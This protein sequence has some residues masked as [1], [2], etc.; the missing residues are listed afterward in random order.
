MENERR[1]PRHGRTCARVAVGRS[2]DRAQGK[3]R[4]KGVLSM[5][6]RP[7]GQLCGVQPRPKERGAVHERDNG[8]AAR[9]QPLDHRR[10]L[11]ETRGS[12]TVGNAEIKTKGG[13]GGRDRMQEGHRPARAHIR[14]RKSDPLRPGGRGVKAGGRH[15]TLPAEPR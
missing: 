6:T 9:L 13:A 14:S 4:G 10:S 1:T 11:P 2:L 7:R 3:G 15:R 5:P 8:S 12:S